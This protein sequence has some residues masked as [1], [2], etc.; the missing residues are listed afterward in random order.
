MNVLRK[1]EIG[2]FFKVTR[3]TRHSELPEIQDLTF[4]N[5]RGG[6]LTRK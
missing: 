6:E 5:M 1:A 3:K 4:T 2:A